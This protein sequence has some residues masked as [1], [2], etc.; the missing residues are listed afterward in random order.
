MTE[1]GNTSK[2]RVLHLRWRGPRKGDSFTRGEN[3]LREKERNS[4]SECY[5]LIY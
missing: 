4:K 1:T 3:S 2:K 5:I